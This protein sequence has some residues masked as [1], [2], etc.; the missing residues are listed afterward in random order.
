MVLAENANGFKKASLNLWMTDLAC[1]V[2]YVFDDSVLAKW[3][4][5]SQFSLPVR[6]GLSGK[7]INLT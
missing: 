3:R 1:P 2:Q 5:T 6:E 7:M 4:I